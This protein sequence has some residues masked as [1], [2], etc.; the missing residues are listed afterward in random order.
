MPKRRTK[1]DL[2]RMLGKGYVDT[3]HHGS[4][5]GRVDGSVGTKPTVLCENVLE[6]EVLNKCMHW[7]KVN[8]ILCDRNNTGAGDID[9]TG[10]TFRY[11]IKDA[12]DIIGCL[13]DG[14]HF[15]IECKRGKG[16]TLSLGQQKRMKKVRANNGVY[17]IVHGEPELK[18]LMGEYL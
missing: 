16:G 8:R 5:Q 3:I 11:G 4:P 2:I 6:K 1:K 10:R 18:K 14:K 7:L 15:E 17:I 9:G 13:P 12:G